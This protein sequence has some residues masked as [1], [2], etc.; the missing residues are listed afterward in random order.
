M[1]R[2]YSLILLTLIVLA[3]CSPDNE[4]KRQTDYL[5]QTA[6]AEAQII[7][8]TQTTALK[9]TAV[10]LEQTA[11]AKLTGSLPTL[12]GSVKAPTPYKSQWDP[13]AG[14]GWNNCG[15]ASIAMVLGYYGKDISV[16]DVAKA[17]RNTNTA[18]TAPPSE[19]DFKKGSTTGNNAFT[20]LDDNGLK[21]VDVT[22][23]D[24]MKAQLDLKRPVLMLVYNDYYVRDKDPRLG[25][26]VP[27]IRREGFSKVTDNK[28]KKV[29]LVDHIVVVTGYDDTNVY[30]NDPLAV[31]MEKGKVISD[32]EVGT[33]FA[34]PI[35]DFKLAAGNHGWY[36]AAIAQK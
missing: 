3:G 25:R 1:A 30:L 4:L 8:A 12:G 29:T 21:P 14:K 6:V 32:P 10:A 26:T 28:T 16:D 31:K 11:Q 24:T 19:T 18:H 36:G 9:Q 5:K 15:P 20:L 23:Y 33:N 17:I 34:V 2:L 22:D 7:A 27:Y 13:D 35:N